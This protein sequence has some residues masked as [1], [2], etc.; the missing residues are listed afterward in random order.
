MTERRQSHLSNEWEN[1]KR[2]F[3]KSKEFN[4][5]EWIFRLVAA[6]GADVS[7]ITGIR[8]RPIVP[9]AAVFLIFLVAAAYAWKLRAE[10]VQLRWCGR[11]KTVCSWVYLH[12][13]L[14]IYFT[15][16]SLFHFYRASTQ[17]PGFLIT[18]QIEM[19]VSESG[20]K[21]IDVVAEKRR[22]DLYGHLRLPAE[23]PTQNSPQ[24]TTSRAE[25]RYHPS[26]NTSMCRKCDAMRPPR[27]HHCR[28]CNRCVL[29][30][31]H[32]CVWLN[33][34]VGYNNVRSFI[35]TL[36]F[37]TL[38]C[39]YGV[40][41]LYKPFYGPLQESLKLHGGVWAYVQKYM[42]NGVTG[43]NAL[44]DLPSLADLSAIFLE[45]NAVPVQ[46]VI[47]VIFP[48]V[49]GVGGILASFLGMH[50]KYILS[51][52]TTLDHRVE[53]A[54]QFDM[55]TGKASPTS[56]EN[57]VN[58]YDQV[59]YYRNW[60]QIMGASWF[61]IFFPIVVAIPPPYIPNLSKK[62]N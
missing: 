16:M 62:E 7:E 18:R 19:D 25:V 41:L 56:L 10:I 55:S 26:P 31:D 53:L 28:V 35:L 43:D 30:F 59:L 27:C 49:L 23:V 51:A 40:L 47:D 61:D 5:F 14:V 34:C 6:A 32:H 29:Q 3:R 2:A 21:L 39:W 48:F 46:T 9:A 1:F 45:D 44:F 60:T 37:V 54:R 13:A 38:A 36:F 20:S 52:R 17:S 58:P 15:V 12:D 11:T 42:S 50:V 4:P 33:N 24:T 8:W 57:W 22:L